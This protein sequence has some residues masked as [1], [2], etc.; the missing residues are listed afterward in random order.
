MKHENLS[1]YLN[2][3]GISTLVSVNIGFYT[4]SSTSTANGIRVLPWSVP[5]VNSSDF[6]VQLHSRSIVCREIKVIDMYIKLY[7][8]V[9]RYSQDLQFSSTLA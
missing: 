8:L 7:I 1:Y 5:V 3:Y 9:S 2:I 6:V 4:S